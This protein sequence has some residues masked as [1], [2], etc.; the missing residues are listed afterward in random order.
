MLPVER[1][2]ASSQGDRCSFRHV[3]Q[4][5]AQKP[6]HTAATLSEPALSRGRSVSGREASEAKVTMDPFAAKFEDRSHA[7]TGRQQRCAQSKAWDVAK[8]NHKLQKRTTGL[9]SSHSQRSG[10]SQVLHQE[11]RVRQ[12]VCS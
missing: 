6:E 8:N 7:E 4:D 5:R 3:T 9:N 1:K 11:S 12:G 10:F 2:K